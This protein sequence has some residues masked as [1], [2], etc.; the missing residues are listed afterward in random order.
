[1][2]GPAGRFNH[3]CHLSEDRIYVFG[4]MG[5]ETE[6][7]KDDLIWT[8]DLDKKC[9]FGIELIGPEEQFSSTNYKTIQFTANKVILL[10]TTNNQIYTLSLSQSSYSL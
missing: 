1:M 3:I 2:Y 5:S 4:G 9:W 7:I 6:R 10:C 8:Y